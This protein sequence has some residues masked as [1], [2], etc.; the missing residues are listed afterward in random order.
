MKKMW[1][2]H[3]FQLFN[4]P[5]RCYKESVPEVLMDAGRPSHC[6]TWLGFIM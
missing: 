3:S 5:N 4:V 6:H 2:S 1:Q